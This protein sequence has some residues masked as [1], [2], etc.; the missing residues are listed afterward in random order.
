MRGVDAEELA[1]LVDSRAGA[2]NRDLDDREL[3]TAMRLMVAGRLMATV[4][5][6]REV[7]ITTPAG[8][9]AMRLSAIAATRA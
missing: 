4:F 5:E 6:G 3:A 7:L 8:E 9:L 1:L 2:P